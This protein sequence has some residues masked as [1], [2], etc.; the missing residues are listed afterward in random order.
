MKNELAGDRRVPASPLVVDDLR[1]HLVRARREQRA[2]VRPT[3]ARPARRARHGRLSSSAGGVATES[4]RSTESTSS[5]PGATSRLRSRAR[6]GRDGRL[7]DDAEVE[8]RQRT[9]SAAGRPCAGAASSR[10]G[11][12]RR[13]GSGQSSMLRAGAQ[14]ADVPEAEGRA[15]AILD[16]VR[17]RPTRPGRPARTT[18]LTRCRKWCACTRREVRQVLVGPNAR[19][20]ALEQSS[21]QV[22]AC[23]SR[24]ARRVCPVRGNTMSPD[25]LALVP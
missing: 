15:G 16:V 20:G 13:S 19:V 7:V 8:P 6:S 14:R 4:G 23:H 22:R 9:R 11:R 5:R 25:S 1:P 18:A 24:L 17:C 3:A 2:K 21:S 10:A 12:G